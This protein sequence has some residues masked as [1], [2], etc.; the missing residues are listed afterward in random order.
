MQGLMAIP[1]RYEAMLTRP[2]AGVPL[3]IR[4]LATAAR[5]GVKEVILFSPG[6]KGQQLSRF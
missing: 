1:S 5:A 2:V 6:I 4:V 3:L